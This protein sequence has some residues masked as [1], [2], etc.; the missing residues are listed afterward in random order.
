M[1]NGEQHEWV[2]VGEDAE[3][4][5]TGYWRSVRRRLQDE[6]EGVNITNMTILRLC[7]NDTACYVDWVGIGADAAME[8]LQEGQDTD[9]ETAAV[10]ATFVCS[11]DCQNEGTCGAN[12]TCMCVYPWIGDRCDTN[13]SEP[14][15]N[16]T[17][18][19]G[20]CA[21]IY[22]YRYTY[23]CCLRI[24]NVCTHVKQRK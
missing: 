17:L 3:S 1:L 6:N 22:I 5:S 12:N 24:Q 7:N 11:P 13:A 19:E 20:V 14:V 8:T 15:F 21:S 9:A 4:E 23:V 2:Q 18:V 10:A 16:V